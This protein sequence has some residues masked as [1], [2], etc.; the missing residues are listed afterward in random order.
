MKHFTASEFGDSRLRGN[1]GFLCIALLSILFSSTAFAQPVR[2]QIIN[3]QAGWNAVFLEVE[4]SDRNPS[5]LFADTPVDIAGT[6]FEPGPFAQFVNEPD[7][8]LMREL[9]WGVWYSPERDD[10]FLSTLRSIYAQRGYLLHAVSPGVLTLEGT[11]SAEPVIWA[12]NSFNL[13]GF[14]LDP[15]AP[16]TFAEFFSPSKA[17]RDLNI[18]R[19]ADGNWQ[20]VQDPAATGMRS[21]EA[22]WIYCDGGSSYQGPLEVRPSNSSGLML[23]E[24][25]FDITLINHADHPISVEVSHQPPAGGGLSLSFVILAYKEGGKSSES[26]AV[27]LGEDGWTQAIPPLEAGASIRIPLALNL[28]AMTQA[29]QSTFLQVRTDL[30]TVT[31]LPINGTREDLP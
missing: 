16:P 17:H 5:T 27:P 30:G 21:G 4:S 25:P 12:A 1:L 19:M 2:T 13:V 18:Y 10:S 31:W 3:L 9:G 20:K 15:T 8:N 7:A 6:W 29:E 26:V 23:A 11:V 14:T 28:A 22:F 24:S